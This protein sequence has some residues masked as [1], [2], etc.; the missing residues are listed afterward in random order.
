[1]EIR[2]GFGKIKLIFGEKNFYISKNGA[3]KDSGI[4]EVTDEV[5]DVVRELVE[6][7]N[8]GE[9]R[10]DERNDKSG[11]NDRFGEAKNAK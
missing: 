10:G 11:K 1:M 7:E 9:L 6:G 8:I 3:D 5:I 2:G 4:S